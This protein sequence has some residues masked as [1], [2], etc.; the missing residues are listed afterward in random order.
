MSDI[1]S[2]KDRTSKADGSDDEIQNAG[3][4][5]WRQ[6]DHECTEDVKLLFED[7]KKSC[8]PQIVRSQSESF[9]NT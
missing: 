9:V 3:D 6:K 2:E 4:T 5:V 8:S 1:V 7:I